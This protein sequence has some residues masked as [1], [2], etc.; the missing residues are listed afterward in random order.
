MASAM[1]EWLQ[2]QPTKLV[3]APWSTKAR[4]HSSCA[5]ASHQVRVCGG[6]EVECVCSDKFD[7]NE[8]AATFD[9]LERPRVEVCVHPGTGQA[10]SLSVLNGN[11][12]EVL[13]PPLPL[14]CALRYAN[15][16]SGAP[17]AVLI[18]R[19]LICAHGELVRQDIQFSVKGNAS[20]ITCVDSSRRMTARG[21]VNC[22]SIVIGCC[23]SIVQPPLMINEPTLEPDGSRS[24]DSY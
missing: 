12:A 14:G 18:S 8:T 23:V 17:G 15:V 7:H 21:A 20:S 13:G 10:N 4:P 16:S 1:D 22:S 19:K 11:Q 2:G 6:G 5:P 3:E 9:P 24:Y